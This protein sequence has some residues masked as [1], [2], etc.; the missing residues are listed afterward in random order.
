L[1]VIFLDID[2]ILNNLCLKNPWTRPDG[3]IQEPVQGTKTVWRNTIGMDYDK[4]E[5]LNKILD[6]SDWSIIISSSWGFSRDTIQALICFGFKHTHRIVGGTYNGCGR[7]NQIWNTI[8]D[9]PSITDFITIDDEP[10]DIIGEHESV[11]PEMR[12][13]F[14]DRVF[15]PNPYV[16]LTDEIVE[17]VIKY[18][19]ENK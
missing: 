4:V 2:G 8:K 10:F 6:S 16:G 19:K 12:E 3:T 13:F 18:H 14:K 11:T 1:R 17:K 5:R 15:S 9:N 7:G